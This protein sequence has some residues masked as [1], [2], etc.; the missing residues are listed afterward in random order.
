MQT[1]TL[2]LGAN[3]IGLLLGTVLNRLGCDVH[4][5]DSDKNLTKK[6]I[7]GEKPFY[8]SDLSTFEFKFLEK[9]TADEKFD[10]VFVMFGTSDTKREV[11]NFAKSLSHIVRTGK[12]VISGTTFPGVARIV[13][14]MYDIDVVSAPEDFEDQNAPIIIGDVRGTLAADLAKLFD[15]VPTIVVSNSTIAEVCKITNNSFKYINTD[16]V[17]ELQ[18]VCELIGVDATEVIDAY[19]CKYTK[20][21][22]TKVG[23]GSYG[24]E[25]R[26]DSEI[27]SRYAYSQG[28]V[29]A[30][31]KINDELLKLISYKINGS[32][33]QV[34]VIG[35]SYGGTTIT[36][37]SRLSPFSF[38]QKL[39]PTVEFKTWDPH[40]SGT[41][42]SIG[43][44]FLGVD[45]IVILTPCITK[46]DIPEHVLRSI[47]MFDP[48]EVCK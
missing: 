36:D 2:I 6:L 16:F 30:A 46:S 29:E 18:K 28:I 38:L 23:L 32:C 26:K 40:I 43:E 41:C 48:W 33:Q 24:V 19:N 3:R 21:T 37:D 47:K 44:V 5:F 11:T 35:L 15:P 12:M 45:G 13:S 39:C 1:K 9:L 31:I 27:F 20:N 4:I 7:D 10:W 14:E 42:N 8:I 22:I 34:G 17:I 25:L